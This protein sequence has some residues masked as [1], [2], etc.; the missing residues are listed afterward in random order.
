MVSQAIDDSDGVRFATGEGVEDF[1]DIR[2]TA[3]C[4][5]D[6]LGQCRPECCE[7]V[8]IRLRLPS[9]YQN[10]ASIA[11]ADGVT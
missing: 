6:M 2:P 7:V 5:A 3:A 10:P 4:A 8:Y 9:V 1:V 11:L